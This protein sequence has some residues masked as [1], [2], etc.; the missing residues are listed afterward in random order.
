M[1]SKDS[2]IKQEEKKVAK[3]FDGEFACQ[4]IVYVVKYCK[5]LH[6]KYTLFN[7]Q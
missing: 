7:L 2:N 4:L 6:G 1:T 5:N 3:Y